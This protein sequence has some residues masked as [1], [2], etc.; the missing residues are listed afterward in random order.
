[1][2]RAKAKILPGAEIEAADGYLGRVDQVVLDLANGEPLYIVTQ[3]NQAG[4]RLLLPVS[5]V[6]WQT[7]PGRVLLRTSFEEARRQ[8]S[9]MLGSPTPVNQP[10]ALINNNVQMPLEAAGP[11]PVMREAKAPVETVMT[12]KEMVVPLV[13]EKL[14]VA[15]RVNQGEVQV[16][17]TVETVEETVN[18]P[19]THDNVVI[20]RMPINQPLSAPVQTRQEGDWLI[21]PVMEEVLVV[22]KQL[23][24]KEEL[25]VHKRMVTEERQVQETVRKERVEVERFDQYPLESAG[26]EQV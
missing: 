24:L 22:Q 6:D 20:E 7:A 9:M 5:L 17:K 1:M 3:P 8:A 18:I 11:A 13:E 12:E 16:H 23:I 14:N 2:E 19:L 21:I 15:K 4:E 10:P 26:Q 25:R